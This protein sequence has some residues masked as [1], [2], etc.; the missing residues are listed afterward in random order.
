MILVVLYVVLLYLILILFFLFVP[1]GK[2]NFVLGVWDFFSFTVSFDHGV[3][4]FFCVLLFI[5][6]MIFVYGSFYMSGVNRLVYFFLIL[7]SFVASM[8]G[9]IVFSNS[10]VLT[11]V[12]WDFLGISSFFPGLFYNNLSSRC[13]AMSTVFTNRVGDFCI[14]LFFNGLI[15]CSM[16]YLNYQFFS[17]LV[18]LMLFVAAFVKGGQYPYG[19]WL[20][21][22]MAAPTP[23]SCLVHSSTLVTAGV[24]LMD[25]YDYLSLNSLGLIVIFFTGGFTVIVAGVCGLFEQ[26]AKKIVALSTMS[27]MGLC[28]LTIGCGLH[29]VSFLHLISHSFF[30]SLLFMQM[31]YL[32]YVNMGQQDYRGYSFFNNSAGCLVKIQVLV[33]V[34]CLCGLMF[35]SGFFSKEYIMSCFYSEGYKVFLSFVFLGGIFLTFCYCFRMFNLFMVCFYNSLFW[36]GYSKSFSLSS[37][38][39]VFFSVVFVSWWFDNF[40]VVDVFFNRFEYLV[41]IFYVFLLYFL[42]YYSVSSAVLELKN[43]FFMDEYAL[44]IYKLVPNLKF[45][46]N[47]LLALNSGVFGLFYFF[48]F[49]SGVLLRGFCSSVMLFL[50]FV[51]LFLFLLF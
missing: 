41:G 26:D 1:Y 27:Q 10:V 33:S 23:V 13:G 3:C 25:C 40:Y 14:F 34:F 20:P 21:K 6:F 38:F 15:L 17:S 7:F 45:F 8:G 47:F 29:Y 43:K 39:L 18:G 35:T 16:S 32:I 24:M 50:G 42:V 12:F 44:F 49:V 19:S 4:M 36:G 28:F 30:K 5:S 31:G 2:W 48:T 11:L 46:D 22:A 9:L 37:I 51:M